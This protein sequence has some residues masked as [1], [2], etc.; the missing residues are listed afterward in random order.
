MPKPIT[1]ALGVRG[2]ALTLAL[3]ITLAL[4]LTL[5][6]YFVASFTRKGSFVQKNVPLKK[7]SESRDLQENINFFP[8][9]SGQRVSSID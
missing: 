3:T 9:P 7:C 4:T 6:F 8:E 5:Q 2:L 1:L